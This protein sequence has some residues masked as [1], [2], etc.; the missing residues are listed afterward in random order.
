MVNLLYS[1]L[2]DVV[3]QNSLFFRQGYGQG[4]FP[5]EPFLKYAPAPVGGADGPEFSAGLSVF[6]YGRL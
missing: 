6:V 2:G 3:S 1:V 5:R 4:S